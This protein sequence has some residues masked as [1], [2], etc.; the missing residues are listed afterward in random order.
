MFC[1]TAPSAR[2]PP[3]R[4]DIGQRHRRAEAPSVAPARAAKQG[5][6]PCRP[7]SGGC[8]RQSHEGGPFAQTTLVQPFLGLTD[9]LY[10][11][12]RGQASSSSAF[13]PDSVVFGNARKLVYVQPLLP[14]DWLRIRNTIAILESPAVQVGMQCNLAPWTCWPVLASS[15]IPVVLIAT[16]LIRPFLSR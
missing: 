15:F 6:G 7:G 3:M 14:Y 8:V 13:V 5:T 10:R 16:I 12:C 9:E 11:H 2:W 4:K 1:G